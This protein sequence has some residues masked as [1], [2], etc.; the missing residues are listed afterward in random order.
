MRTPFKIVLSLAILLCVSTRA[1]AESVSPPE[2]KPVGTG[3]AERNFQGVTVSAPDPNFILVNTDSN[4][5]R[6]LDGGQTWEQV[7]QLRGRDA[8]IYRV[9][10]HPENADHVFLL[11]SDGL[12]ISRD[13][14]REWFPSPLG[15][16]EE[17]RRI[18]AVA[19][20]PR[21]RTQMLMA[22]ADGLLLSQDRGKSWIK[23]FPSLSRTEVKDVA[24]SSLKK[25]EAY[26]ATDE[27]VYRLD[28]GRVEIEKWFDMHAGTENPE[29]PGSVLSEAG[30][31]TE[32]GRIVPVLPRIG[33]SSASQK[34]F[35]AART[36]LFLS[37]DAGRS[38]QKL[39]IPDA[40]GRTV[41]DFT[42][43]AG[44]EAL[45]LASRKG[46]FVWN[47]AEG[48]TREW[49]RG[50][51]TAHITA[52]AVQRDGAEKIFAATPEGLFQ[53]E[54]P[55]TLWWIT[56][57]S[58]VPPGQEVLDTFR[59][60]IQ[61]EPPVTHIQQSAV[62]YAHVGNGK[63]AR[64]QRQSRL[65]ALLPEFSIE[66]DWTAEPNVDIDRGGTLDKDTFI[67]G[68]EN[69]EFAWGLS[70][71]WDFSK[72]IWSDAQTGI[73]VREKLMVELRDEILREVT[74]L[75]FERRRAQWA[76][77]A[78]QTADIQMYL[79]TAIRIDE[80]AAQIDALTGNQFSGAWQPA[81]AFVPL[82]HSNVS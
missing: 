1:T 64:W 56:E 40:V 26:A 52:V 50:L 67:S 16:R 23:I 5:Y 73:D 10:V 48:R 65:A 36:G 20:H 46:F 43:S 21:D 63:I 22:T 57:V 80:L 47:E 15:I 68:P 7:F 2:W 62:R 33:F 76:L 77:A 60:W 25:G 55:D 54:R 82:P 27:A 58:A 11:T 81:D 59:N 12:Y 13:Q 29:M 79:D 53:I 70:F 35:V 28:L 19:F 3:A 75:Y 69:N 38:W 6:S 78:G 14:G 45:F 24:Y 17:A 31:G 51:P 41:S 49:Y 66:S 39:N 61:S 37:R 34:I 32:E 72:F 4:V 18:F 9:A 30:S 42:F 71:D 74:R 44:G 8:A